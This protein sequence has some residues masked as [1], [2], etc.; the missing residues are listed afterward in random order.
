[1][2]KLNTLQQQG[3]C[4]WSCRVPKGEEGRPLPPLPAPQSGLPGPGG[5]PGGSRNVLHKDLCH[6]H[7]CPQHFHGLTGHKAV[8]V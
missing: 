3:Q 2:T 8:L 6:Q 5:P 4:L 1:M 7:L